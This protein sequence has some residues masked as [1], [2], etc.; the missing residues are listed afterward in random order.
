MGTDQI[1]YC[2]VALVLGMLLANMLKNVCGCKKVVEGVEVGG[3]PCK[4]MDDMIAEG[5]PV[6]TEDPNFSKINDDCI[7]SEGQIKVSQ[8]D[9]PQWGD[10]SCNMCINANA[11]FDSNGYLKQTL[12]IPRLKNDP[13]TETRATYIFNKTPCVNLLTQRDCEAASGPAGTKFRSSGNCKWTDTPR[14]YE[15]SLV[16]CAPDYTTTTTNNN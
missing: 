11:E 13:K 6:S 2:V 3:A 1:M 8:I 16:N 15:N 14:S 10:G 12:T 9:F 5:C 4:S 7:C